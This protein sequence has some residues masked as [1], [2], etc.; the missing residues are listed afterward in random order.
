MDITIKELQAYLAHTYPGNRDDLGFFMKLV[1]E[2]G[3]VAEVLNM[4]D[5]RKAMDAEEI[6]LNLAKELA[7]V[8]HYAAA[9]ATANKIDL[10]EIILEKDR[11]AAA[12]YHH[13]VNLSDFI[14][15]FRNC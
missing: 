4:R 3:E 11:K 6:N 1:E 2:I 5:G 14:T 13:D 12:K 15:R 9:I 8:I 10:T 7:D